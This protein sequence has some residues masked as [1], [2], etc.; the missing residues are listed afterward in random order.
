M[1]LGYYK[2]DNEPLAYFY[3]YIFLGSDGWYSA[4]Y[5]AVQ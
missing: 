4:T 1:R 5:L 3:K 2:K